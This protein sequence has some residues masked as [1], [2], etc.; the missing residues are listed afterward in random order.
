[1]LTANK[2]I[3]LAFFGVTTIAMVTGWMNIGL[4]VCATLWLP[5]TEDLPGSNQN[6]SKH[7]LF[8]SLVD[9]ISEKTQ[10][11]LVACSDQQTLTGIAYALFF[12]LSDHVCEVSTYHYAI[13][14]QLMMVCCITLLLASIG[15]AKFW[16][17]K[18]KAVLRILAGF[19]VVFLTFA[20]R[21]P[22]NQN[23]FPDSTHSDMFILAVTCL[24]QYNTINDLRMHQSTMSWIILPIGL[25]CL[26]TMTVDAIWQFLRWRVKWM[27]GEWTKWRRSLINLKG[28]RW[29]I[30][31][32]VYVLITFGSALGF[33]IYFYV[34]VVRIRAWLS[35]SGWL[36]PEKKNPESDIFTVGEALPTIL[37]ILPP[38]NLCSTWKPLI[39]F[40]ESMI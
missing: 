28:K 24:E 20:V 9:R 37:F 34:R 1:V 23:S 2:R 38:F 12:G 26:V 19:T 39:A 11:L 27:H 15:L 16:E 36:D 35:S 18:T 13:L 14:L 17:G 25:L 8:V 32:V 31:I 10:S 7:Y 33:L 3:L 5:N 6:T 29:L 21:W 4:Q 30:L 22:S 40:S